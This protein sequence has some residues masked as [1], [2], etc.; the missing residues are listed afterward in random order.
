[1][2][3]SGPGTTVRPRFAAATLR[4]APDDLSGTGGTGYSLVIGATNGEFTR[5]P[6]MPI[7][8]SA[9]V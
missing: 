6:E 4:S 9:C 7:S 8:H 3:A 1:M 5:C 2:I